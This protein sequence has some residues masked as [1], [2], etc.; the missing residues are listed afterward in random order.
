VKNTTRSLLKSQ[1]FHLHWAWVILTVCFCDLLINYS[2]RLGYTLIFPEMIRSIGLRRVDGGTI[3]NAYLLTY[4]AFSPLTGW[5]SDRF[6][7]RRVILVCLIVLGIGLGFMGTAH[8]LG[9]ACLFYGIAGLGATGMWTPVLALVQRWFAPQRRGLALGILSASYGLGFAVL[10]GIFPWFQA[11]WGWRTLWMTLAASALGFMFVNAVMIR[12][13]PESC[14]CRPWGAGSSFNDFP[15]TTSEISTNGTGPRWFRTRRFWLI[16]CSYFAVSFGVYGIT[17]FMV[18]YAR[19]QVG[20]PVEKAS[21]LATLHGIGQMI[22][23]LMLMPMSDLLG[24]RR[25]IIVSNACLTVSLI[26]ILIWGGVQ[27]LL[28]FLI[29]LVGVSFGVTFPLYGACAGDYF[30]RRQIGTVIGA[31]TPFYGCGAVLT[32]WVTGI[33]CDVSGAY[34]RAFLINALMAACGLVLMWMVPKKRPRG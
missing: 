32:H 17:T 22:G 28:Y 8:S 27:P 5:L 31:W 7:V 4:I 20:L 6:G 9:S 34:D 13:T 24:R 16:G 25:M 26:G 1:R 14:G 21:F 10:G 19:M 2:G 30:E 12:E 33:L 11:V 15:E 29:A 3:Y 23:V 18:D